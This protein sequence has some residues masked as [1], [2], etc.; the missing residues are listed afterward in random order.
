MSNK[1]TNFIFLFTM[2][3][4]PLMGAIV[5][6]YFMG[7]KVCFYLDTSTACSYIDKIR[8]WYTYHLIISFVLMCFFSIAIFIDYLIFKSFRL[9][10]YIILFLFILN[11]TLFMFLLQAAARN[12]GKIE[13]RMATYTRLQ[14]KIED[15]K[16]SEEAQRTVR[17]RNATKE[18][19]NPNIIVRDV[20]ESF[21]EITISGVFENGKC[22][23]LS[24]NWGDGSA[25]DT[26]YGPFYGGSTSPCQIDTQHMYDRTGVFTFSI[27]NLS[28]KTL[29][30]MTFNIIELSR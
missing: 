21:V 22:S 2:L 18:V 20:N 16:K 1:L 15:E 5:E 27:R 9:H 29:D 3:L 26:N 12:I 10:K 30:T 13:S 7:T 14:Q 25:S 23:G 8:N 6:Y 4:L 11:L 28:G 17:I 19:I 24:I